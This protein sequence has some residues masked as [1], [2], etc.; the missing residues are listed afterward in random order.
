ML[1]F[2]IT[3]GTGAGKSTV[4]EMFRKQGIYVIDGDKV[5][6][7]VTQPGEECLGILVQYFGNKILNSDS[8]MNRA[9]TAE[10][11]FTDSKK[12][13]ILN[14]V[15][16]KYINKEITNLLKKEN[17]QI[18]AIDG[19]VIIGSPVEDRCEFIVSVVA[20]ADKR[21]KRIIERDKISE[22]AAMHRINAQPNEEFY[23]ENSKY[24]IRNNGDEEQLGKAVAQ[25]VEKIKKEYRFEQTI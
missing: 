25:V 20:D 23:I 19:A 18:A 6:R 21:M 11:V 5:A 17:P 1:I 13:A 7:K 22:A 10:I 4:S 16:H 8:T 14:E 15:T 24:L 12:L 3:G 9:K 2:G